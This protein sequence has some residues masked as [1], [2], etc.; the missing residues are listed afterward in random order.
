MNTFTLQTEIAHL[1]QTEYDSTVELWTGFVYDKLREV[2]MI[3]EHQAKY[4][5]KRNLSLAFNI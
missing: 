3:D 2:L 5:S 1:I 4:S